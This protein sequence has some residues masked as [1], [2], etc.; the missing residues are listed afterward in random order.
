MSYT[1][2]KTYSQTYKTKQMSKQMSKPNP[3][4][5]IESSIVKQTTV[6]LIPLPDLVLAKIKDYVF[7][8]PL[9]YKQI[10]DTR[11]H[12]SVMLKIIGKAKTAERLYAQH[13][14]DYKN[15]YDRY[16]DMYFNEDEHEDGE[17][18]NDLDT[19][20]DF[21]TRT[22]REYLNRCGFRWVL[23]TFLFE[24]EYETGKNIQIY[25]QV[26]KNGR[27]VQVENGFKV[28]I[29]HYVKQCYFCKYCGEY[30]YG[31]YDCSNNCKCRCGKRGMF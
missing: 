1:T 17:P 26:F 2:Y 24:T 28:E 29:H 5:Q 12:K 4:T 13:V 15:K 21:N 23:D 14:D 20:F 7:Y 8:T 25:K 22:F 19:P 9:A 6:N 31:Q 16:H 3:N 27:M 10:Q 30:S 18:L 11:K